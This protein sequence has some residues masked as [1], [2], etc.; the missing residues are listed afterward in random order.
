METVPSLY[1]CSILCF[2]YRAF[3]IFVK[4]SRVPAGIVLPALILIDLQFAIDHSAWH[5]HGER[6]HP[7]VE[8]NIANLLLAW[9]DRNAPIYH[10]RHDSLK[11]A[12]AYRHGQLRTADEVHVLSLANMHGEFCTVQ[13]TAETLHLFKS[14]LL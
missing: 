7:H 5:E 13:D 2:G 8:Q 14:G 10:I 11:P 1:R 6:N 9:R 3:I 12:S 4:L